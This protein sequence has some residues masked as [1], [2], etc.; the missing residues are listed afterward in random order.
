[1]W[2]PRLAWFSPVPPTR[3]GI[4]A[5]SAE[6]LPLLGA[7]SAIDVFVDDRATT[8]RGPSAATPDGAEGI[9]PAR[10]FLPR[11]HRSAYDLTVYQLGNA[12]CH[13]YMWPY[14]LRYRGLI[15][16]HDLALHHSRAR[17]LLEQGRKDD[18]RAE[19]RYAQPE[20]N[21]GLAE[22]AVAGLPGVL[23][24]FW[25]L[26]RVAVTAGRLVA[27]HGEAMAAAL[28]LEH[29]ETPIR[30]VRMGVR[31]P[32]PPRRPRESRE[33]LVLACYGLVT[34]E[35]RIPQILRAFAAA[36]PSNAR[37]LLVGDSVPHYDVAGDIAGQGLEGRVTL[38]GFVPDED[39]DDWL[40]QADV[41]LCLRWPT[42]RETS[43]S[44]LRCLAAAKP[45]VITD[46]L[47]TVTVPTLDPRTWTLA[48]VNA[49]ASAANVLPDAREAV[50]VSIDILDEDHSLALALRRLTADADLREQLGRNARAWWDTHH[51]LAVMTDDY[52]A[53]I[54]EALRRPVPPPPAEW[55]PHLLAD[56]R[57]LAREITSEFGVALDLLS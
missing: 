3:S 39:L 10:E 19:F 40:A 38:T 56:G 14:L 51:R 18:Y 12:P 53:A 23:Y 25:P 11:H 48:H 24:Y 2:R 36:V 29:P 1:M 30:A 57:A 5:Y 43:A 8:G 49:T 52:R 21:P 47:Q 34:P 41:C 31:D 45:T 4:S 50:A 20:A 16:L 46:L 33:G 7:S 32:D 15:V 27:V 6:I 35:K 28:A 9:F 26:T 22:A 44:W 42:A 54:D 55:P 17:A 37:L 13:D